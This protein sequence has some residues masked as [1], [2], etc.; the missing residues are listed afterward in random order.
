MARPKRVNKKFRIFNRHSK[1]PRH[2][3]STIPPIDSNT[4]RAFYFINPPFTLNKSSPKRITQY[5]FKFTKLI[6][7]FGCLR[8]VEKRWQSK[9]QCPKPKSHQP[10]PTKRVSQFPFSPFLYFPNIFCTTKRKTSIVW[11]QPSSSQIQI[12]NNQTKINKKKKSKSTQ[13]RKKKGT[14][15]KKNQN[16]Q[17]TI[18]RRMKKEPTNY[19]DE[20]REREFLGLIPEEPKEKRKESWIQRWW[21]LIIFFFSFWNSEL[22]PVVNW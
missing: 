17:K 19:R 4:V 1:Q 2:A 15:Q 11:H 22:Q 14:D 9:L 16:Q 12:S 13:S 6:L 8:N 20:L 21:E 3:M 5:M 10:S 7:L 18:E